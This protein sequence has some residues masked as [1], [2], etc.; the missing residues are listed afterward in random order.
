MK[1]MPNVVTIGGGTGTFVVLS[2]LKNYPIKLSAVVSMMDSGGSTGRLKDQLGVLPPGDLRQ[3]LVALSESEDI[4]R[5]LFTYRFDNGDLKGH[6]FGNIFLSALEKITGSTQEAVQYAMRVLQTQGEVIPV[7]LDS[8]SLC[9]IYEDGT[10]FCQE[11]QIDEYI[12]KSKISK[13]YLK[14]NAL[15]NLDAKRAIERAD[16]IIFGPGDLY[17]SILPNLLVQGMPEILA[18]LNTKKIFITNLMTRAG[19]TD[20]YKVSDFVNKIEEYMGGETLDYI[21]VNSEPYDSEV[22]KTYKEVDNAV[23]VLDDLEGSTYHEAKVIRTNL[24]SN[25]MFKPSKSD[26]VKRSLLR[27]DPEKLA[28]T[29]FKILL[30]K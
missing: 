5:K 30:S 16:F 2:G 7:T 21:L 12:G 4:W 13:M 10:S 15:I 26:I 25:T 3:A 17:T 11:S 22:I 23:P 9:A 8:S 20:D 24:L 6:N 14:P 1:P 18:N 28:E 27:H 19:Q 29:L